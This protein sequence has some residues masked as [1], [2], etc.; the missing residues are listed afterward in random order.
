MEGTMTLDGS[1][2][3]GQGRASGPWLLP[4]DGKALPD[5][6]A[7]GGKAWS[8][9]RMQALGLPVPPAFVITTECCRAYL[10]GGKVLPDG[11]MGAVRAA[12]AELEDATGRRFGRGPRPLLLSVRSG[13]AISM[14]GMMDTVLNLGITD[15]AEAALAGETGDARFARDTHRRF[16]EMYGRIVLRAAV[17]ELP[18]DGSPAQWRAAVSQAGGSPVPEEPQAQLEAAIRAVFESW[19][20]RRARRY[21]QHHGIPDDLGTAVTVQAMV[22]G[23]ADANSGTGVLF[24]RNPLTGAAEP[25]GEFLARAQGED[26]VSGAHDPE[27]LSAM[28]AQHPDLHGD[29]LRAAELLERQEGDVQD[30]EFTVERGRLF[31]LQS[32]AA[33]R[34]ARAAV[35]IAVDM[36]EEGRITPEQALGRVSPEQVRQL[37]RP[38]L[39]PGAE[40]GAELLCSG[41]PA[42]PGV[43]AGLA[44]GDA[45][46]VEE[47][48]AGGQAV[49]LVRPSTS[50]DDVHG[51]IL[52]R[53]V[54]TAQGGSTSHAAVVSRALGVPCVVGCGAEIPALLAGREI[55]VDGGNGR[56]YAGRLAIE[57]PDPKADPHLCRL[58]EWAQ[59]RTPLKVVRLEDA[60]PD[61]PDLD[62]MEGGDDPS[63]LAPLLRGRAAAKGGVFGTDA[64][65]QAAVDAGLSLIAAP[66]V[67]PALLAAHAAA[68]GGSVPEE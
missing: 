26:V 16:L 59:A 18:A 64:G 6:A 2:Q 53:A 9:A 23:N 38:R 7:I 44:V 12:T 54:V 66:Q 33:K 40:A 5:R 4:L 49:V 37:L 3:G 52:A 19:D 31:L 1:T 17:P 20:G 48:A 32:R 36:V 61:L 67:L 51:M 60:P 24:S 35:T 45:D 30:I 50:P 68:H 65:V 34:A 29:L 57:A 58:Q 47:L 25:Y 55:T 10:S 42:S 21:R 27:P 13:A 15:E 63:A 14:P 56:I 41:E 46:Q 62:R 39:R 8:I 22:F 11:L 43:G 28:A